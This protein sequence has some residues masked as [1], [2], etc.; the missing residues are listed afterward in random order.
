MRS[1]DCWRTTV[2]SWGNSSA[3]TTAAPSHTP[4]TRALCRRVNRASA[5]N[6]SL[7]SRVSAGSGDPLAR[8]SRRVAWLGESAVPSVTGPPLVANGSDTVGIATLPHVVHV[9]A[10]AIE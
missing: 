7:Y 4:M 1:T 9:V 5:A 8:R 3:R 2:S 6:R 10:A